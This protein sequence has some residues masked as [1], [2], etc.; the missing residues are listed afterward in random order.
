MRLVRSTCRSLYRSCEELAWTDPLK[1]GFC[2][3][4]NSTG[5]VSSS[6]EEEDCAAWG[7][8]YGVRFC[9]P[10]ITSV[11]L[12]GNVLNVQGKNF[13]RYQH[14]LSVQVCGKRCEPEIWNDVL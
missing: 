9:P 12:G 6:R 8:H 7:G 3:F 4:A 1:C 2:S 13:H 5:F 11:N 10:F 14:D